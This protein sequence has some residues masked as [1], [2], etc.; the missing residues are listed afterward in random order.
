M[1]DAD[2]GLKR[3]RKQ[4]VYRTR[5]E[6]E[7]RPIATA[8]SWPWLA[9][10]YG[11]SWILPF[12]P[13]LLRSYIWTRLVALRFLWQRITF[14]FD[15]YVAYRQLLGNDRPRYLQPLKGEDE[16]TQAWMDDAAF[17]YWRVAG[18]N[19]LLLTQQRDLAQL[20]ERIPLEV[21]RIEAW[22]EETVHHRVSL[23]D[24]AARGALFVV[25]FDLLARALKPEPATERDSTWRIG[26]NHD[27]RF[28]QKYL[29]APIGVFLE[30]PGFYSD[31]DLDLVPLAIQIDQHP[32]PETNRVYYPDERWPWR[33]AK[34]YFQVADTNY[35]DTCGHVYRTHFTVEPFCMASPRQLPLDHP[36]FVLLQPHMRFTLATN[37][38]AYKYFIDRKE[39]Y[40]LLYAGTLAVTRKIA[41]EGYE[42]DSFREMQLEADLMR[43]GVSKAPG[44]YPYRED[45]L[46]WMDAIRDFVREY[47]RPKEDGDARYGDDASVRNDR[48]LQAWAEELMDPERGAVRDLVPGGQL[49]SVDKL[50]DLLSQVIFTAG[51]GHASQHFATN[52][53]YRYTP[54]FPAAAYRPPA[55]DEEKINYGRWIASL[56]PPKIA[57]AQFHYN[58]FSNFHYDEF[59]SYER[60]PLG[61]SKRATEAI[62]RLQA[63]LKDIDST[64]Q[65]RNSKRPMPYELLRPKNVPN[66]I[67]I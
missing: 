10:Q 57:I 49:D 31:K 59:G 45:A 22:L 3:R 20:R 12:V 30:L 58:T 24:E 61:S 19:A 27:S 34:M 11:P 40:A 46:L 62:Q 9:E 26:I 66:S 32:D 65:D 36:V 17:G 25:D 18:A 23:E 43:R 21:E 64:I 54:A 52:Y 28:G 35:H 55:H 50:V 53:F 56:A 13:G 8:E 47:L 63:A 41:V 6:N 51:P 60:Y 2:R 7:L 4:Y 33:M 38:A 67:N 37:K 39:T 15:K 16:H 14:R 48:H 42:T 44:R 1:S 5:E 29:P